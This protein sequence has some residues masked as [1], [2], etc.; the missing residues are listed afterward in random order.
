MLSIILNLVLVLGILLII[1]KLDFKNKLKF[2]CKFPGW[3]KAPLHQ[4]F[5]GA[6]FNGKCPRCNKKVLQD[7][8]GDWF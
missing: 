7:S 6:S 5:D 1:D 3:H 4:G 2:F 8:N